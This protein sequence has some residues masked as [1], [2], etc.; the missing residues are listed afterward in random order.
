MAAMSIIK[1]LLTFI[2]L[3]IIMKHLFTGV[4]GKDEK[5]II[6]AIKALFATAGIIMAI[7]AVEFLVVFYA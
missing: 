2:G 6:K 3:I 4:F 5:G 1:F 7:T